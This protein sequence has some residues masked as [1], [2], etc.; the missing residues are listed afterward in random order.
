MEYRLLPE[1][2]FNPTCI[3]IYADK[4][5]IIIWG[6]PTYGIII[7]SKQVADS[8][9]KYF[10]MMWKLAKERNKAKFKNTK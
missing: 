1:H 5:A 7:K 2:L 4:V 9:R 3:S 8:N 10:Q 6:T